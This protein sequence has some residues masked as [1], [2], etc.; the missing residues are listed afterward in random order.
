M[1]W[2]VIDEQEVAALRGCAKR[3]FTENRMSGDDMRDMAQL[4]TAILRNV[5]QIPYTDVHE[6]PEKP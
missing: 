1:K 5:V 2:F 4:I 6:D 3:L